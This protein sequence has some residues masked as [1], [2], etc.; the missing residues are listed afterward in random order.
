MSAPGYELVPGVSWVVGTYGT[1]ITH[2]ERGAYCSLPYPAAAV[3]DA[4]TRGYGPPKAAR[5]IQHIGGFRDAA[6]ARAYVADC[7]EAWTVDGLLRPAAK[8]RSRELPVLM[9]VR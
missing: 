9:E 7:L 3:W 4:F 8:V 6:E 2:P 1:L 5:M